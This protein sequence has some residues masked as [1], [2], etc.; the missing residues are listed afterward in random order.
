MQDGRIFKV[1]LYGEVASGKR[2]QDRPE[3]PSERDMKAVDMDVDGPEDLAQDRS[4]TKS[5]PAQRGR[6]ATACV[7]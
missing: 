4:G 2:A 3:T 7:R 5:Q 6:E 1:L